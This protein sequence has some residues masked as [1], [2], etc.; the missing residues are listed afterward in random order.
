MS[1][2]LQ[3]KLDRLREIRD[4]ATKPIDEAFGDMVIYGTGTLK[5]DESS[6]EDYY[7]Y[8][9][10]GPAALAVVGELCQRLAVAREAF[11][12]IRGLARVV[13]PPSLL[14]DIEG[15]R[16]CCAGGY[17]PSPAHAGHPIRSTR[18]AGQA[19]FR[20]QLQGRGV[21]EAR[22]EEGL[23]RWGVPCPRG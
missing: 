19:A 1:E 8:L 5:V 22:G 21:K 16:G 4:K 15:A 20:R 14:E 17:T 6:A 7:P 12:V 2:T 3:A 9:T 18:G 10:C 11:G 23:W 13:L